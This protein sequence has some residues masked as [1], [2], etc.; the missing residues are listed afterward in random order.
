MNLAELFD[1]LLN[2]L[3][4]FWEDVNMSD[5]LANLIAIVLDFFKNIA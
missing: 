2:W 5:W 1:G 4:N 3:G